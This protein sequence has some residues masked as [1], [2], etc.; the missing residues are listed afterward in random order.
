MLAKLSVGTYALGDVWYDATTKNP[1]NV[2]QG[3]SGSSAGSAS[4]V[5]AGLCTFAIG[6]ETLGSIVSPTRRCRVV[7]LRP[8]FG[9]V[10]RYGCMPLSWTMDKIGP[11]ARYAVDCGIVLSAIQGPDGKDPTVVERPLKRI[12][13]LDL[14]NLRIG[15]APNQ[16]SPS[17]LLVLERLKEEGAKA[18]S[19]EYPN[20]VPQESLLACLD[21]ESACVFDSLF[22]K[23][24]SEEDFGL[25][26]DSFRKS[27]F[28][29]GIHYVQSLRARTMLIQETERILRTVDVVLGGDDLLRTNLTGH[30]SM[31]IRC[32]TQNL[33]ARAR[34]QT[35]GIEPS[36]KPTR[37]GPRTVKLTAKYFGDAMLVAAG[38]SIESMMPPDPFLPPMFSE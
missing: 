16:L 8:S 32:G 15:F 18:V 9:R 21:V 13:Q 23:A 1:W 27:Q 29:R 3:S 5:A 30:P 11:I 20:T 34:S 24:S 6:S 38:N 17:E 7:G 36:E 14:K 10:S 19:L 26:G 22:R 2:S 31:I 4:A 12:E 28:V 33:D 35:E 37:F 25:W